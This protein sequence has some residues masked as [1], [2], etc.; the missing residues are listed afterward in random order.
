MSIFLSPTGSFQN[1]CYVGSFLA[2][3]LLTAQSLT[4][5]SCIVILIRA[6]LRLQIGT[7][8]S[9]ALCQDAYKQLS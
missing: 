8:E 5:L 6:Q 9:S 3:L 2:T 4:Q 7:T 1:I